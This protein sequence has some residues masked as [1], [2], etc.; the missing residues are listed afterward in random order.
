MPVQPDE[1]RVT[2]SLPNLDFEMRLSR[3]PDGR[4]E[5]VTLSLRA[6]PDFESAAGLLAGPALP[7][8]LMSGAA[9]AGPWAASPAAWANPFALWIEATRLV[10]RPWFQAMQMLQ[11]PSSGRAPGM[12]R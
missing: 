2:A 7:L 6:T 4:S 3:D 5:T 12:R 8:A 1:T 11:P 9:G 10:W